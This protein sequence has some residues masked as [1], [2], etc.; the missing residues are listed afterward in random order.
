VATPWM[1]SSN[2]ACSSAR[3]SHDLD[4]EQT[5]SRKGCRRRASGVGQPAS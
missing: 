2:A 5:R 4:T 3:R 1:F